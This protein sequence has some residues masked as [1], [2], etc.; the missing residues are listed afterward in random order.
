MTIGN[1]TTG[2]LADSLPVVISAARE[3]REFD[4]VM[5]QLCDRVTLGEGKGLDWNEVTLAQLTAQAVTEQTELNNPQQMS[6]TLFTV[7]PTVTGIHTI[8]TDRVAERIDSKAYARLGMLAM[9]AIQRKK[10]EDGLAVLDGATTSL[11]GA[12]NTLAS[13][14]I[15]AAS[16]RIT[17]NTTEPAMGPLRTVLHG[18][19][20]KDIHDELTA[21]I[22]TYP[23]PA[24]V[25]EQVFRSKFKGQVADTEVYEDGNITIDSGDDAKGGTFAKMGIVLVEGHALRKETRREP[26]IG[27]GATSLWIYDEYAY[28]ERLAA[29]TTGTW[30]FELYSDATAPTS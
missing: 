30:L 23:V 12:G 20:I 29:N 15:A 16:Y 21:G 6:D 2:S 17:S 27:G 25:S 14:H 8:I 13:G 22:G 18:F 4:G 28:G 1:S 26:H 24:G 5:P 3:V 7:R 10:D 19:Q 11:C 9:N